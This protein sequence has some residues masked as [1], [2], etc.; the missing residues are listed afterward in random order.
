[1][2]QRP[3]LMKHAQLVDRDLGREIA[4]ELLRMIGVVGRHGP[5]FN[6]ARPRENPGELHSGIGA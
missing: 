1:M 5:Q 4:L 3:L 2:Q 6:N